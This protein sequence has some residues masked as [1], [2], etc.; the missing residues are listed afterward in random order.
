MQTWGQEDFGEDMTHVTCSCYFFLVSF[1]IFFYFLL[2]RI[3][4]TWQSEKRY[5]LGAALYLFFFYD[6]IWNEDM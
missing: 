1:F 2:I 5:T 3:I 6:E 4:S